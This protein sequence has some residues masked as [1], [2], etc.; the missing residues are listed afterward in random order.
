MSNDPVRF[1]GAVPGPLERDDGEPPFGSQPLIA[2]DTG[3]AAIPA[4]GPVITVQPVTITAAPWLQFSPNSYA[5]SGS[6]GSWN[7]VV[8]GNPLLKY[9]LIQNQHATDTVRLYFGGSPA[10]TNQGILIVAGGYIEYDDHC[11][12]SSVYATSTTANLIPLFV[13]TG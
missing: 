3:T 4:P 13:M 12:I 5:A 11:P 1:F 8:P 2:P 6:P 9:I 10:S 7:Q